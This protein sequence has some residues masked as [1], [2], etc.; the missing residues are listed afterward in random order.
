M[1]LAQPVANNSKGQDVSNSEEVH[2]EGPLSEGVPKSIKQLK[3][4]PLHLPTVAAFSVAV[5][6]AGSGH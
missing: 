4:P 6:G 5:A 2:S 3:R 1:D